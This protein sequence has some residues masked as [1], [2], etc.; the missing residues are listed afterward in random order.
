MS[1]F[2]ML[3]LYSEFESYDRRTRK[4]WKYDNRIERF[5]NYLAELKSVCSAMQ[6]FI[7]TQERV[8]HDDS[9]ILY[10][11]DINR[12]SKVVNQFIRNEKERQTKAARI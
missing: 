2:D 12:I 7:E 10:I 3:R 5:Y 4:Q 8:I 1:V 6:S 11:D 9:H